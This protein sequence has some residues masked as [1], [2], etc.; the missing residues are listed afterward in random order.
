MGGYKSG[1]HISHRCHSEMLHVRNANVIRLIFLER[2]S[3]DNPITRGQVAATLLGRQQRFGTCLAI[4]AATG[5]RVNGK[6]TNRQYT[7]Y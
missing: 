3:Y 5:F 1:K 2:V 6:Y 7:G 4:P